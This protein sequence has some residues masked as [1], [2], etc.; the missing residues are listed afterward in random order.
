MRRYYGIE[1]L[2]LLS[3]LTVILYHYRHFFSPYSTYSSSDFDDSKMNLPFYSILEVF[4][5][6][7]FYGVHMFYAISGFVFAYVYLSVNEKVSGKEFFVNRFARLYPLHFA[8][9]IIVAILQIINWNTTNSFQIVRYNDFYHFILQLFFISSWGLEDGPSFNGPIWSVSIE[10]FIYGIFFLLLGF[11]KK[12]RLFLTLLICIILLLI[13]KL[14]FTDSLHYSH[15]LFLECGRLFF[16]GVLVYYLTK[17]IKF[18]FALFLIS[19]FCLIFSLVGNFKTYLFCP[20]MLLIFVLLEE[21]I[22]GKKMQDLFRIS[23]NLTYALYLLHIPTQLTILL[24]V[25]NL[26]FPDFIYLTNYFFFIF[27]GIMISSAY[28]C[29][30]F[31]ENP[32][33][34]K[35]RI[36]L[37]RKS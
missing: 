6:K 16:L 31:F 14:G 17:E 33:N 7:G 23:G 30:R 28:L 27:F 10:I 25:K 22:K 35:I 24:I 19:I 36:V 2:R 21:L 29:F 5:T 13:S 15:Q 20:S 26:N 11:L 4:Y 37:L 32:M 34:K 12:F 8:T 18:K 3:S 9:L 1:F